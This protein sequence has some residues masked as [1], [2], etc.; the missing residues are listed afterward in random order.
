MVDYVVNLD[1]TLFAPVLQ[2]STLADLVNMLLSRWPD[3]VTCITQEV[4]GEILLW[5]APID[6]VTLARQSACIEQGLMPVIGIGSQEDSYYYEIHDQAYV[7]R[8]WQHAVVTEEQF[9]AQ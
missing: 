8:D 2:D 1:E 5:S 9:I 4:D 3:G 7:A 6:E